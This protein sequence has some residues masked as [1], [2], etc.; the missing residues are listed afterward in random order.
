MHSV[1]GITVAHVLNA[2]PARIA[3]V[4]AGVVHD[5]A[6]RQCVIEHID[7]DVRESVM[8]G[9]GSRQVT[10][11]RRCGGSGRRRRTVPG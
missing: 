6:A 5:P 9:R 3:H 10:P 1:G 11:V 7:P 8:A 4:G 2:V